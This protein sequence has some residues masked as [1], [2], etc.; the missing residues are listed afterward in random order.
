[1][2]KKAKAPKQTKSVH[3]DKVVV[4]TKGSI[5]TALRFGVLEAELC[6]NEKRPFDNVALKKFNAA[7]GDALIYLMEQAK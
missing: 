3:A 2:P 5:V 6:A 7:V 1:M 4:K